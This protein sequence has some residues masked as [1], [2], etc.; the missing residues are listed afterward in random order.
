M[1]LKSRFSLQCPK[2]AECVKSKHM[3]HLENTIERLP[4]NQRT[5]GGL[6]FRENVP[7]WEVWK[8]NPGYSV[9]SLLNWTWSAG[10]LFSEM[11][12]RSKF[13]FYSI[14]APATMNLSQSLEHMLLSLSPVL[15]PNTLYL[16]APHLSDFRLEVTSSKQPCCTHHAGRGM[17]PSSGQPRAAP[18]PALLVS[19]TTPEFQPPHP[20]RHRHISTAVA[21]WAKLRHSHLWQLLPLPGSQFFHLYNEWVGLEHFLRC[22]QM[23]YKRKKFPTWEG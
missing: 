17:P 16:T 2:A 7:H 1:E 12:S 20:G 23:L 21:L 19:L 18:L 6:A 5:K 8:L 14:S 15:L 10:H 9:S 11:L 3:Q 13:S 22:W 4:P